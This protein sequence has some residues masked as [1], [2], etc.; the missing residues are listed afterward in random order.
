MNPIKTYYFWQ[1]PSWQGAFWKIISCGCFAGINA[2]VRYLGGGASLGSDNILSVNVILFFQNVF[3]F[4]L[5]LPF[6]YKFKYTTLSPGLG[7]RTSYPKLHFLRVV[8]AVLGIIFMYLSLQKMSI[9]ESVALSFTG[10]AFTIL[11]AWLLLGESIGLQR[12][13]AVFLSI[14][15]AL[16]ISYPEVLLL[17]PKL[18]NSINNIESAPG[19][20]ALFPL[21]SALA[22][23]FSKLLTRQLAKA[24]ETPEQLTLFLLLGMIPVSFIPA[25][26][27]WVTPQYA[28]WPWLIVLGLLAVLAHISFGKAY[29]LA[30]VTFLMP[31]GFSKFMFSMILGYYYFLEMPSDSLW[32]GMGIMGLSLLSLTYKMPL[33]SI[34]KRFKSS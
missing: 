33:Y 6:L 20:S 9:A 8:T 12:S 19:F 1:S 2:V 25:C 10:P 28:H 30:E 7:W 22:L 31:F 32:L 24:G 3:G 16:I 23:A 4:I 34:A 17:K 14:L 13:I 26:Y 5:M 27:E 15:A 11:G 29:A 21:L 18:S